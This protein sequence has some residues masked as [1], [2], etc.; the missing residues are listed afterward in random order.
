MMSR[1]IDCDTNSVKVGQEVDVVYRKDNTGNRI[2][3][4]TLHNS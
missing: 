4:F 2:P 3:Y 1:I